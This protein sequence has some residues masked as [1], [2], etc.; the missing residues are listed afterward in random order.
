MKLAVEKGIAVLA[1]RQ[2]E[3]GTFPKDAWGENTAIIG[4][5]GLAFL[6]AGHT[7]RHPD[8]GP[9]I[10]RSVQYILDHQQPDGLLFSCPPEAPM[11]SIAAMYSHGICTMFLSEVSG[12]VDPV[13]QK[14][15][16]AALQKALHLLLEAQKANPHG[17]WRY[18]PGTTDA[19]ICVTVWCVLALRSARVNGA[20]IP[21]ESIQ[22]AVQFV[23][24][25][26]N[27]NGG[28]GYHDRRVWPS[29]SGMAI[30]CLCLMGYHDDPDVRKAA[31]AVLNGVSPEGNIGWTGATI[32]G[33]YPYMLYYCT[34]AMY[35][36]G[37][38]WWDE[39][40]PRSYDR[41]L[42][43]QGGDGSWGDA[44]TTSLMLLSMTVTYHQLPVYQR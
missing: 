6:S 4:L 2:L 7:P 37:G 15:I 5:A 33:Q 14:R 1:R 28:F 32:P 38:P 20:P 8:Y 3:N 24:R 21:A 16:D 23:R 43:T 44:Y 42:R 29:T 30:V 36:M 31:K 41:I 17:G 10:L 27:P 35:Q 25:L 40:I 26:S 34:H 39:F 11:A 18:Q 9:P 12:M 13:L 22:R 19:D